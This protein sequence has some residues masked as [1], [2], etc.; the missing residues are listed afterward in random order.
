MCPRQQISLPGFVGPLAILASELTMSC[1]LLCQTKNTSGNMKRGSC[2]LKPQ[3]VFFI[4]VREPRAGE[5]MSQSY[6]KHIM[7][8]SPILIHTFLRAFQNKQL[9]LDFSFLEQNTLMHIQA[10]QYRVEGPSGTGLPLFSTNKN[11]YRSIFIVVQAKCK[12]FKM[13]GCSPALNLC[14]HAIM[15]FYLS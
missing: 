15:A 4:I 1:H 14:I 13:A 3:Q 2:I 5:R 10:V 12:S 11:R 6:L 9:L 8:H 7:Y